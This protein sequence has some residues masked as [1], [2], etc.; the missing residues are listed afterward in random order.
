MSSSKEDTELVE[1]G[2]AL[3]IFFIFCEIKKKFKL[4]KEL[5]FTMFYHILCII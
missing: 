5:A 2:V 1:I 3:H 4:A